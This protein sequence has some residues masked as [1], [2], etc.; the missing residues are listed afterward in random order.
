MKASNGFKGT[1]KS[2]LDKKAAEDELFEAT[3]KKE[4][5]NLDE[6]CNYVMDCAKK[7]GAAGYSDEEV[8]GWAVHY[9]DE[10]DVKNIKPI[11]GKVIVNRS[12][13][14]TPEEKEAAKQKGIDMAIAEAKEEA[15]K[16]LVGTVE[17]SEEDLKDVKQKAIDKVVQEQK[18][19]LT[20][21]SKQ[22]KAEDAPV[23]QVGLF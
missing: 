22:T 15:K 7:G 13:E 17:L 19:Q 14:L 5:K 1:I 18:E 3:Y 2:Y 12:V 9:Y 16:A 6:C 4:N 23:Q 8:F 10:D 21:K 11:T 20:K